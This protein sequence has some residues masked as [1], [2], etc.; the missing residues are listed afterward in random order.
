[1]FAL[2]LC[3]MFC[4]SLFVLLYFF[5]LVIVLYALL[6]FTDYASPFGIFKLFLY[7]YTFFFFSILVW[8][9]NEYILKPMY[10]IYNNYSSPLSIW[11]LVA[12]YSWYFTTCT[13]YKKTLQIP[14]EYSEAVNR[15]RTDNAIAK[16]KRTKGQTIFS[17]M[18]MLCRS[19]FVLLSFFVWPLCCLSFFDLRILNTP[20]VSTNSSYNTLHRKLKIE[21]HEPH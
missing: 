6:R 1:M 2:V 20:L 16:R 15:R 9:R 11:S 3:E 14:K 17:F 10:H 18:C 13:L 12:W 8:L 5:H 4:K 7:I 21:Q 19:L